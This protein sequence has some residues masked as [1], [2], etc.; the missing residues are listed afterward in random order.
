MHGNMGGS[1]IVLQTVQQRPSAHVGK[2]EIQRDRAGLE[3]T[4]QRNRGAAPQSHHGLDA[5]AV[6]QIDHDAGEGG[7]VL[8]DQ[9][10]AVAWLHQ[11][12]VVVHRHFFHQFGWN[13]SAGRRKDQVDIARPLRL[14]WP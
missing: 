1:R 2:P 14:P 3:F 5:A 8:H 11:I 9:Q 13:R 4:R 12:A 7:V 6:R 10:H